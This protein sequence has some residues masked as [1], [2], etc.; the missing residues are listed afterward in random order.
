[1][2]K[3]GAKPKIK[4]ILCPVDFSDPSKRALENA[5]HLARM[6]K[7]KL[8]VLTVVPLIKKLYTYALKYEARTEMQKDFNETWHIKFENFLKD[9]NFHNMQWDKIV[10]E[11]APH[12]E[13]L[14]S[15]RQISPDHLI[16][17]STGRTG[18]QRILLGSTAAKVIREVPC[19]FITVKS[20]HVVRL[21]LETEIAD[22]KTH[23]KLGKKLTDQGLPRDAL[24]QF[25]DCLK[26][27]EQV[28]S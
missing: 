8:T 16:L 27:Y 28:N 5:I 11:G 1:M 10:R 19:S 7:A 24:V 20:E 3:N 2:V 14:D 13:I 4:K 25:E 9:F 26:H 15:I 21:K 12:R 6:F 22:L 18:L 23:Y 17:G